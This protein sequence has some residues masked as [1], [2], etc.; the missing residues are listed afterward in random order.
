MSIDRGNQ[1]VS[2]LTIKEFDAQKCI[3]MTKISYGMGQTEFSAVPEDER[4]F[5]V[6]CYQ[7]M[8]IIR[9]LEANH[10]IAL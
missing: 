6:T 5:L 2:F 4:S 8:G 1:N 10:S 9:Y 3:A 7:V